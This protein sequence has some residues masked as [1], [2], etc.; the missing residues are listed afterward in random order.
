MNQEQARVNMIKQQVR[1]WEVTDSR[2]IDLMYKFPR[3]DFVPE[4]WRE[5]A[6]S[7]TNITVGENNCMLFPGLEARMLQALNISQGERVLEIGTGCGYMTALLNDLSGK[8]ISLDNA[9]HLQPAAKQLLQGVT[10]ET[11]NINEGWQDLG[12]FDVIVINGSVQELPED[13]LD[14][15]NPGGRLFAV[16]G[17]EPAMAATLI[18]RDDNGLLDREQ[19]FETSLPRAVAAVEKEVFNF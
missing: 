17:E 10:L 18:T 7:D 9:D 19:L 15:L 16:I 14:S 3:E 12:R 5:L 1:T 8:V 6:Y 13:L 2:V 4:A 11:G